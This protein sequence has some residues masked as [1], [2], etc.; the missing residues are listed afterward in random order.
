MEK[1]GIEVVEGAAASDVFPDSEDIVHEQR[2]GKVSSAAADAVPASSAAAAVLV[3]IVELLASAADASMSGPH[4]Y[5]EGGGPPHDKENVLSLADERQE[6]EEAEPDSFFD[7]YALATSSATAAAA[8]RSRFQWLLRAWGVS[9]RGASFLPMPCIV[10]RL[11][12]PIS[13]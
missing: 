8:R 12:N 13:L 3:G 6:G 5:R 4:T 11:L 10:A 7:V 2:T 9:T 1:T